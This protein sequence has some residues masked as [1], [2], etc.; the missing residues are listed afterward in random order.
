[1]P[2]NMIPGRLFHEN[3]QVFVLPRGARERIRFP[4]DGPAGQGEG[5]TDGREVVLGLRPETIFAA[6]AKLPGPNRY[7]FEASVEVV[8]PT[9]PDT[10][11]VFQIGGQDLVAR[12]RPEDIATPGAAFR[13]EVDMGKAKLFDADTGRSL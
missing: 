11:L 6:G 4:L 7:L 10:M 9:G 3:G 2:M 13:F 8:E 12:V 5:L 1:P